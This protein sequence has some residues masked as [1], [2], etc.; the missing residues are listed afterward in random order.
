MF[1]RRGAGSWGLAAG[2]RIPEY[3]KLSGAVG[4][5][6]SKIELAGFGAGEDDGI[7]RMDRRYCSKARR[8]N[9]LGLVQSEFFSSS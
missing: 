1:L 5:N 6:Y 9:P 3:V 4:R 2:R 7:L 8:P